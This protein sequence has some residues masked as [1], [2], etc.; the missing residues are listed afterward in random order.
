[1][2]VSLYCRWL[3]CL[4]SLVFLLPMPMAADTEDRQDGLAAEIE[5]QT[6]AMYRYYSTDSVEQFM[7]VTD[8]LKA[9]TQRSG[10]ERLFYKAWSNQTL[11]IF[12]KVSRSQG[13]DMARQVRAYA[14]EHN[15]KY[16]LYSSTSASAV[17]NGIMG[18]SD[19][20]AKAHRECIDYLHRY[21]PGESAA[22][23]YVT[24]ARIYHN[25]GDYATQIELSEKAL[26]EPDVQ[27]VH[28]LTAYSYLCIARAKMIRKPADLK[29]F[30]R[31]YAEYRAFADKHTDISV[32][33]REIVEFHHAEANGK[34]DEALTWAHKIPMLVNR[35][36]YL[37]EAYEKRGQY[38]QAYRNLQK[39]RQVNDSANTAEVMKQTSEFGVQLDVIRAENEAKDLRLANQEMTLAHEARLHRIEMLMFGVVALLVIA[40][41]SIY[42]YRRRQQML[43][44]KDAYDRLEETT[45][46]KERY[47]SELRIARDIQMGMVPNRFPAFPERPDIDL[48]ATMETAK[49]V[50][51]DFYDYFLRENRLCFCVGDV[52]GKGVPASMT[53]AVAV[54]LFRTIAKSG[55]TPAQ[56]VT[57]LNETL[58]EDNENGN[59]ITLFVGEIDLSSGR[60]DFC[61][62]GHNPPVVIEDRR[63]TFM[64]LES[65]A[66]VGLWPE[67]TFVEEYVPDV[68][69][70]QLLIYTDGVTEAENARQEQFSDDRLLSVLTENNHGDACSTLQGVQQAIRRHVD[71]A[72]PSDDMTML[73]V[74]I[75]NPTITMRKE[76]TIKNRVAELERVRDFVDDIG[77][78]LNLAE[79]LLM[80][81]QLVM[82]EMVS[83]VIFYA[84]PE[85]SDADI[86]LSAESDSRELTFVLSDHGPEFDPTLRDD[87]D[88]SLPPDQREIGGMGIFIVKNLMN[89]VTYQRL[90]GRNL[91]TMKKIINK[92]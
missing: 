41:L 62:A 91:L 4:L 42:L 79:E 1:M 82:E 81:L 48:Y 21:F 52:S 36:L 60:L 24:L 67:M 19:Q 44:L 49:A 28:A 17:M 88:I 50:G 31:T 16:G 83:N 43:Q 6:A 63:A 35:Y 34:M 30:N 12:R 33:L 3:H 73:C 32:G 11:Y 54:S 37:S 78:S 69:G 85:G 66:P 29:N 55:A 46:A 25:R 76:L 20:S 7:A 90:E 13:L 38:E 27:P 80:N 56:I 40:F 68:R 86:S 87:P 59:F 9:L 22:L 89:E 61:N 8:S 5:R 75:S 64:E 10:D 70:K 39:Y 74:S 77:H 92:G 84:H 18:L 51:G 58:S 71:G 2:S 15:S 57:R 26:N 65:N 45:S 53:M 23:H 72:E 47:E 14:Q